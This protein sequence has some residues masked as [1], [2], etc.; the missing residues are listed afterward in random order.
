MKQYWPMAVAL[1]NGKPIMLFTYDSAL[2]IESAKSVFKSWQ[3][4]YNYVLLSSW[5]HTDD[6]SEVLE[7]RCYVDSL[8]NVRKI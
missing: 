7:H 3:D 4:N 5:I 2:S 6:S 8:G 1:D